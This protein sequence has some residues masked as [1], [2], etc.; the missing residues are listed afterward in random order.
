MATNVRDS[1]IFREV[2]VASNAH[3]RNF[4]VFRETVVSVNPHVRDFQ[5]FRETVVKLSGG[6]TRRQPV[7]FAGGIGNV[8]ELYS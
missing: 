7:V 8:R 3:V 2:I 4:Q 5:V 6:A 1:Q